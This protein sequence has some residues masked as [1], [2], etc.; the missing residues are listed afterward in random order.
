MPKVKMNFKI[1]E[2]TF[3]LEVDNPKL[4]DAMKTIHGFG[5]VY[6]ALPS[7]CDTCQSQRIYLSFRRPK[8]FSYYLLECADCGAQAGFGQL[9]ETEGLFWKAEKMTPYEGSTT[10]QEKAPDEPPPVNINPPL[11]PKPDPYSLPF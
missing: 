5:E 4:A 6:G 1:G 3:Q 7:H 11:P 2:N 8:G 10:N 9:K